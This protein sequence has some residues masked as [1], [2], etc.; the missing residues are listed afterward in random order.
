MKKVPFSPPDITESEVNLVSEALRSGWI[1][2]GPK[3]KEFERLIAMCCQTEQ[4]VCLNSATACM[5]LILRVLDVGPGDEVITSAYTYTATASVT[6]HVGAK[7][8]MVDTAPDSFEM[9]YDKLADA[10]TEKTKVV[11]PVDLAGVVCDYDKIFAA[12]ESKKHLFSP[13]NDIQKAYGRV[14]VLADAAHAFGAKWHGKMCGEIADF[15]SFSFHAVKNLTTAEGGALTWR[16]H[17]G[18]DNES[19]YK[20]FQ[21]L[22]LHGQNKD[23]LAKTRL[24][25]WEYDIVA[26]Y[27]KCNMTD[28]MAGIGLAQLKRYPE[29]LYRRRQIIERYNEGLKGR[30]VQVLDHFGDDHSSSGHLYLVRLLGEDVEYRNAVIERMAERGIACNVH[31]KPLP[32]MTAYKNLGFDIVDYPNA[33]NQYHNEITL[34]LHTSLTNEDVE[35]VISNFVDI[36]TQ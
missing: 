13:A 23:A 8:V 5:E 16:N 36:I 2:T 20:Q 7:V 15:T 1:T 3:T 10:I 21:L 18:V 33:Y 35:Y 31:Y 25:A 12:V 28:V 17:D 11:L 24:G 32:M 22:S 26:P 27:Y 9:D 4:A 6:C 14:I 19:L 30:N 34:P 29:M